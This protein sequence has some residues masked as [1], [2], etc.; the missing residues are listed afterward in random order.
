MSA[1]GQP[2]IPIINQLLEPVQS[3]D[4]PK[5]AMEILEGTC[6]AL[7]DEALAMQQEWERFNRQLREYEAAQGFTPVVTWPSQIEE[8]RTR[9]R[10]LN[11]ELDK[12]SRA[13]VHSATSTVP[14]RPKVVYSSPVKNLRAAAEVAKELSCLSG[15]ALREQQARLNQLLSE[16]SKQ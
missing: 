10:D 8:V 15:E 7:V 6:Q 14:A 9:G 13:R 4:D 2:L 16:A 12:D 3:S 5:Q 1:K 11:T